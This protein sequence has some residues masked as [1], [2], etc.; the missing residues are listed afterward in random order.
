MEE[1]IY[2]PGN[3]KFEVNFRCTQFYLKGK[4]AIYIHVFLLYMVMIPK[5]LKKNLN[6][7][8]IGHTE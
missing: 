6:P 1:K 7:F 3:L 5:I 2:I 4:K 8:V